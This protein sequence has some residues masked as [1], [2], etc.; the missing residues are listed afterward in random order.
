MPST[1]PG[2]A[3][4]RQDRVVAAAT[5]LVGGPLGSFAR[6]SRTWQPAAAVLAALSSVF[7]S[8]GVAE[9]AHC[10]LYGWKD[11]DQYWHMCYS[12]L[13]LSLPGVGSHATPYLSS[14]ASPGEPVV[15]G[16]ATW[17]IGLLVPSGRTGSVHQ[18]WFFALAAVAVTILLILLVVV[19]AATVPETPWRAA[20]VALSPVLVTAGLVS[21]DLLGVLLASLGLLAWS[22]RSPALAGV[23]LALAALARTYPLVIILAIGIVAWRDGHVQRFA[24]LALAAVVTLL[25]VLVPL[26]VAS[27]GSGRTD[28][29]FS[30]Y[31]SWWDGAVS[32]GSPWLIPTLF[33][34]ELPVTVVTMLA[35][36]GWIAAV[37]VGATFAMGPGRRPT[38]AQVSFVMVAIVL[39]TGKSVTLQSVLWLLPLIALCGLR[40][41]DHLIWASVEVTAFLAT[42]LYAA[43]AFDANRAL[44]GRDYAIFLVAR[45]V[46]VAWLG[47]Q[48]WRGPTAY[49]PRRFQRAPEA[50][51]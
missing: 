21:L 4:S 41:R 12:D 14:G 19:T 22:R 1:D 49:P 25:V 3:P 7:I 30:A 34:R 44:P 28:P 17:F 38:V 46:A 50:S 51:R 5:E 10:L 15:T 48:V 36:L 33:G 43:Q 11:P 27:P 40:W 39:V 9:K 26:V 16:F 42:W 35:V 2:L 18:Q 24:R 45:I 29:V 8:L 13:P 23:A 37:A 6:V 31:V 20:H 47:Y 32:Y